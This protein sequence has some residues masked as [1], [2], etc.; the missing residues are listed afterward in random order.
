MNNNYAA[1]LDASGQIQ[2]NVSASYLPCTNRAFAVVAFLIF[3]S[4]SLSK[5][6]RN[7]SRSWGPLPNTSVHKGAFALDLAC[8]GGGSRG[9]V[10]TFRSSRFEANGFKSLRKRMAE[11]GFD[12]CE[13][14]CSHEHAMRRLISL[15]QALTPLSKGTSLCP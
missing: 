13:C 12:P 3:A 10:V 2:I 15:C 9:S 1:Q 5:H 8:A 7:I 14:I 11:G 6:R 4:R